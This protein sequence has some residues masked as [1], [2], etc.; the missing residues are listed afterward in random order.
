MRIGKPQAAR[1]ISIMAENL[2]AQ[3]EAEAAPSQSLQS[4]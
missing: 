2:I 1:D 3:A 4:A